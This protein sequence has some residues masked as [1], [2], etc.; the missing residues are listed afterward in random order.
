MTAPARTTIHRAADRA[1]RVGRDSALP[2]AIV[3]GAGTL[4]SV[5]VHQG[6]FNAS[7]PFPVPL[8]S[9][10][11]AHYCNAVVAAKPWLL[12]VLVPTVLVILCAARAPRLVFPVAIVLTVVLLA[13]A[14]VANSLTF[15]TTF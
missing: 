5:M 2:A 9:T 4:A 12:L 8:P 14:I 3:I 10:P 6:C 13:N 1:L 7:P 15:S 11:R